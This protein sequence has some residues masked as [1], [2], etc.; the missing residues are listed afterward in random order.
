[1]DF[2][3]LRI[4]LA[5]TKLTPPEIDAFIEMAQKAEADQKKASTLPRPIA[6]T[7]YTGYYMP[8]RG[9][10]RHSHVTGDPNT[11]Q[12][13][14][15]SNVHPATPNL[16]TETKAFDPTDVVWARQNSNIPNA[17]KALLIRDAEVAHNE[18]EAAR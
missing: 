18:A 15:A 5:K 8:E 7:N 17:T 3:A 12:W 14:E 2:D 1:M 13:H 4:L 11:S 10:L 9:S 6:R 16:H